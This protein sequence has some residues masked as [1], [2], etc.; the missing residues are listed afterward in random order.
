MS[1]RIGTANVGRLRPPPANQGV[2]LINAQ[3][4]T[5]RRKWDECEVVCSSVCLT[6]GYPTALFDRVDTHAAPPGMFRSISLMAIQRHF[7]LPILR[8][9]TPLDFGFREV[10]KLVAI[11][12][13]D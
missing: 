10:T 9:S 8:Q 1:V 13:S 3:P 6:G 7:R 11:C 5:Y 2:D 12:L 4:G